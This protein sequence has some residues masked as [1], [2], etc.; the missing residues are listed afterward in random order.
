MRVSV[1]IPT[2]NSGP[3]VV[4]AVDSVLAQSHPAA[5]VIV[6][7]DGST[8]DTPGRM[9][10]FAGRITYIRQA[11][12]RVAAARNTGLE[13]A[14]GEA[15]AFLDA[16]DVW[17][18]R[19]LERQVA[20]L[21]R[22]PQIGLLATDLTAWPGPLSEDNAVEL[23]PIEEVTLDRL[24]V[25]NPLATSSILVRRE[26]IDRAGPFDTDLFGPEDYD[27]WIRC[28]RIAATA[29]LRMPLTGYRD[30]TGSLSK[31]AETMR[32]GLLRIH[33]KLDAAGAWPSPWVRRRGQAHI[34]Y[35]TGWMHLA[36]GQPTEA[37]RLLLR[38]LVTYPLPMSATEMPYVCGRAR[39]LARSA[40]RSCRRW[41]T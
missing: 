15:I 33:A 37:A 2:Y 3:L 28:T 8:D 4:E 12:A 13:R 14:T 41:L 9:Q 1:I 36:G 20:A 7:D 21:S 40:W 16:D 10:R 30:T 23:E 24:L 19:K 32:R 5:E 26:V 38:S 6:V 29:V 17:H 11:N 22:H 25:F 39:L 18:P 31:Q 27:L 35:S 34:D